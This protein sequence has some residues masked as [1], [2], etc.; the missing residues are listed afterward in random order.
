M[1]LKGLPRPSPGFFVIVTSYTLLF[2][3]L[4]WGFS[5]PRL[6]QAQAV[7]DRMK[8]PGFV[9]LRADEIATL[10]TTLERHPRFAQALIGRSRFG[11][12]EPTEDGWTSL[13]KSHALILPTGSV[14]IRITTS[15]RGEPG[16]FPVTVRFEATGL[17]RSLR[18]EHPGQQTF[19]LPPGYPKRPL[20]VTVTLA[21]RAPSAGLGPVQ[22]DV[23]AEA[24]PEQ[25]ATG[26]SA[27]GASP[28]PEPRP[29]PASDP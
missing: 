25:R 29:S 18:F 7:L 6:D 20:W 24:L 19:D 5:A 14:S 15:S 2:A 4:C 1:I 28:L 11:H 16:A 9:G 8:T 22:I 3:F 26:A 10:E 13:E 21:P 23:D 27:P 17:Q 12:V